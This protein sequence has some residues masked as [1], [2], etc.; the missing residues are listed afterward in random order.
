MNIENIK[1]EKIEGIYDIQVML[2]AAFSGVE[3][4]LGTV[5]F[6][7]LTAYL[8]WQVYYSRKG[9]AKR[10][11]KRLQNLYHKNE[12]TEHDAIYQLCSH[13]QNGLK[14]KQLKIDTVLPEKLTTHSNKWLKFKQNIS[15]LRYKTNS[16]QSLKLDPVFKDSLFWLKLWP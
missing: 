3:L 5:I 8:F 13:L 2:P 9:I 14:L 4:L 15:N 7:S 12:I 16:E 1:L 11:I 6:M 10:E